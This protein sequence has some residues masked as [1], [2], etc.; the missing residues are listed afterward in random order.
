MPSLG[1]SPTQGELE[2]AEARISRALSEGSSRGLEVLGYGEISSVIA[3]ETPAGRFALKRLPP[4]PDRVRFEAYHRLFDQYLEK[5]AGGGL[6]LLPSAMR[7]VAASGGR[8]PRGG[9]TGRVVAYC[10]QP[11]VDS[12]VLAPRVL[13]SASDAEAQELFARI[14]GTIRRAISPRLGLDGQLSNW[15]WVEGDWHYLDVTTPLLRDE[16][17]RDRLDADLFLAMLPWALRGVVKRFLLSDITG[18]YFDSRRAVLDVLG[19]LLKERLERHLPA[20][21]EVAN[22][23][24]ERPLTA[25][26]VRAY[27][28]RDARMWALLLALRRLDRYWQL[29]VRRRG[30]PFLLPGKIER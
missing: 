30:Y 16:V 8:S 28:A 18:S 14:L 21:L 26:E 19:N 27:Y 17:G 2:R 4:F 6:K 15:V 22:R 23:H 20:A 10:V 11:I 3:L 29:E 24:L 25:S 1:L 5:L 9:Q 7:S 13:A 12:A